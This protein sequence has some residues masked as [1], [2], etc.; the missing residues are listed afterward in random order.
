MRPPSEEASVTERPDAAGTPAAQTFDV[1]VRAIVRATPPAGDDAGCDIDGWD[2]YDVDGGTQGE[3]PPNQTVIRCDQS[4]RVHARDAAEAIER[5]KDEAT[6]IALPERWTLDSVTLWVDPRHRRRARAPPRAGPR[7]PRRLTGPQPNRPAATSGPEAV[8]TDL[9]RPNARTPCE[10][11]H[12]D[13]QSMPETVKTSSFELHPAVAHSLIIDQG[14]SM[15]NALREAIMNSIDSGSSIISVEV[16]TD[17]VTVVDDG[18]GFTPEQV[19]E[20]L[21]AHRRAAQGR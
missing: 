20:L 7:V 21:L 3:G 13:T 4:V 6:A 12:G 19:D 14:S 1:N 8:D 15:T 11:K 10:R 17:R 5:A 9:A 18:S 2:T 16:E